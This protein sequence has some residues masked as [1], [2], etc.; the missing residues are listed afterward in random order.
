MVYTLNNEQEFEELK[1]K[2]EALLLYFSHEECNVCKVLKPKIDEL[3]TA[4]FPAIKMVYINTKKFP[5]I[6]GQERIF[7][8]PTIVVI[9]DGKEYLRK[10]RNVSLQVLAEEL[11]RPYSLFFA[12]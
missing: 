7:T 2:E 1:T 11:E 4:Q 5:Q 6:A 3:L 12:S 9:F 10:S 8:V